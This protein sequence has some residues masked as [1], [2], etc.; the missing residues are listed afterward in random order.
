MGK[1]GARV[2]VTKFPRFGDMVALFW[3]VSCTLHWYKEIGPELPPEA[4]QKPVIT[5]LA[6]YKSSR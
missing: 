6:S 1:S 4:Y 3:G 5:A 2:Y